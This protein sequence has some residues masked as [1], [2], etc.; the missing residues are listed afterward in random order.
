MTDPHLTS[1]IAQCRLIEL[2]VFPDVNGK[3]AV[4][5]NREGCPFNI[6]RFFFLYDV[7]SEAARGGHSHFREQQLIIAVSGA[8]DV[9]ID[10]GLNKRRL[11]MNRPNIGLYIPPGIWRELDNFTSGA[12]CAVLSSTHFTEED[13]V[14]SYNQFLSLTHGKRC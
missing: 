3:L 5:G 4:I 10:D 13:Y 11:T 7:P 6:N 2:A 12:V 8:F 1:A 14:R 9:V